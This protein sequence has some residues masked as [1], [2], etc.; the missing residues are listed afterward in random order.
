LFEV[1]GSADATS[2]KVNLKAREAA[3]AK[4]IGVIALEGG[5]YVKNIQ[6]NEASGDRTSIVFS[7]IKTGEAAITAEEAALF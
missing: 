3:L 7:D 2:W 6:M 5:I 4:A 1:E